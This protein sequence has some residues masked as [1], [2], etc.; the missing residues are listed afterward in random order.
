MSAVAPTFGHMLF[1]FL[2]FW[3]GLAMRT[4]YKR[5]YIDFSE[6]L[7]KDAPIIFAC[8]HPNSAIDYVFAPLITGKKVH[9]LV[10]G[11]VFEHPALNRI[12]RTLY[13][14][15]VYRF[16][17][18]FKSLGKNDESFRACY[19]H[20]D[21]NKRILIFSEGICVQEKT[22]QP[23]RKG[24]ARLALDYLKKHGGK[25]IYIVPIATN[26]TRFRSFRSSVM[27]NFGRAI[28]VSQYTFAYESNANKAYEKLTSDIAA[29][30][31]RNFI[32]V[33]NYSDDCLFEKHLIALRLN[34]LETRKSWIINDRSFFNEEK[35]QS[36]SSS[37]LPAR[38]YPPEISPEME[39]ILA[40]SHNRAIL[41][42]KIFVISP[43]VLAFTLLIGLPYLISKW[44]VRTKIKDKIFDNTVIIFGTTVI[45]LVLWH[46]W[47]A[48]A[49]L[50]HGWIGISYPLL[51]LML[52]MIGIELV[53]EFRLSVYALKFHQSMN[54]LR[55]LGNKLKH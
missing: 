25:R 6:E 29:E 5:V 18:G 26:Y 14:L 51:G 53:D 11:D 30:L 33:P 21:Q 39:G 47:M 20:F 9:V 1:Q 15:P 17:D 13:M 24:T 50:N 42:A 38:D 43:F 46:L 16:R 28:D 40:A 44:I 22:L 3:L 12:F 54:Q 55:S 10:R 2:K 32:T 45:G 7:P 49:I 19:E 35:R 34:R 23:L 8:T 31:D 4:W 27:V 48:I 52:V 41:I 36:Q 37:V